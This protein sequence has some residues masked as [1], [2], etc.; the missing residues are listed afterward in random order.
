LLTPKNQAGFSGNLCPTCLVTDVTVRYNTISHAA[1]GMQIATVLSSNNGAAAAGARYSIHDITFDD[2]NAVT[3]NGDGPLFLVMNGWR[4]NGLNNV[5]I[6]HVTGFGDVLHPILAIG[7]DTRLPKIPGFIFTNNIV[8]SGPRPIWS[9]GSK[10]NCA[11]TDVPAITFNACFSHYSFSNN[12][13]I[14]TS[15]VY[16]PSKWP[17]GN[18][19]PASATAVQFVNYNNANGGDYH[20]LSS[21]PY[22]NAGTDGRDLGADIDLI[23]ATIAGVW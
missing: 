13:L 17:N 6:N 14:A 2:I 15:S 16:P 19:F 10:T 20:L 18:F 23:N 1:A 7:N 21:S 11:I 4:T 9:S 3:Y 8:F 5:T 12:A 22:K